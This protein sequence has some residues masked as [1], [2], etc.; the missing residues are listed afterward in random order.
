[1]GTPSRTTPTSRSKRRQEREVGKVALGHS[2]DPETSPTVE[3]F[4]VSKVDATTGTP[5]DVLSAGT[6]SESS[7]VIGGSETNGGIGTLASA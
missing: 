2:V 4:I 5:C 1:M 6:T 7:S 3:L